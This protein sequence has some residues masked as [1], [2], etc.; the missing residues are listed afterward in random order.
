MNS[1]KPLKPARS[2]AK[3]ARASVATAEATPPASTV[4][5]SGSRHA[6]GSSQSATTYNERFPR[7]VLEDLDEFA[8]PPLAGKVHPA[9]AMDEVVP[10]LDDSN[11]VFRHHP[12]EPVGEGFSFDP[13]S[14]DAAA[15]LA[16]DLGAEFLEGATRG[17]DMSDMIMSDEER[18]SETPFLVEE[19]GAESEEVYFPEEERSIMDDAAR[20]RTR[21]ASR[22]R[23]GPTE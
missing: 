17:R 21:P 14:A 2:A 7:P 20:E 13:D 19:I 22:K 3:S 6:R 8:A 16:G 23:A 12:N 15:D 11:R 18:D 10:T 9:D 1:N 4:R 5:N